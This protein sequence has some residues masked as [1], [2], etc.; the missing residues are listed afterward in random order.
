MAGVWYTKPQPGLTFPHG[1]GV[2]QD[3]SMTRA[4]K[5]SKDSCFQTSQ[6]G[7]LSVSDMTFKS[8][9]DRQ[10][11]TQDARSVE[12]LQ[13]ARASRRVPCSVPTHQF[14]RHSSPGHLLHHPP[15]ASAAPPNHGDVA[16]ESGKMR[17]GIGWHYLSNAACLMRPHL[18]STALFVLYG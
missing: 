17:T 9:P 13:S 14:S 4:L 3:S 2:H 12:W 15:L 10:C 1:H 5:C 11:T 8:K 6:S 16:A 18:F 7:S